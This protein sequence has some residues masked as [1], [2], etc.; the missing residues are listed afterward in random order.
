MG[1][2]RLIG[3][4]RGRLNTKLRPRLRYRLVR[5]CANRQSDRPNITGRERHKKSK[6]YDNDRYKRRGRINDIRGRWKDRR[7]AATRL[8]R[9]PRPLQSAIAVAVLV[10]HWLWVSNVEPVTPFTNSTTQGNPCLKSSDWAFK[11]KHIVSF[12]VPSCGGSE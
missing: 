5:C 3:L 9:C 1:R 8:Y 7:R 12:H 10:I 11:K 4:T 6:K 2:G